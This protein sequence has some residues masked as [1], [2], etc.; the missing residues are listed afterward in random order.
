M[1]SRDRRQAMNERTLPTW[2]YWW[3]GLMGS[4]LWGAW[5]GLLMVRNF[6]R[7][8]TGM[9]ALMAWTL[10][11]SC[12]CFWGFMTETRNRKEVNQ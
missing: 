1:P 6:M 11:M 9:T 10:L 7:D 2:F 3:L 5:I 4:P 12:V 8:N